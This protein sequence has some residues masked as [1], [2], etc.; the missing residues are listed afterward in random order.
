MGTPWLVG[1]DR[2]TTA[3]CSEQGTNPLHGRC[4][5]PNRNPQL[6]QSQIEQYLKDYLGVSNV[7]WLGEGIVGDDT[8]GHID[9]ITRFVNPTTV[10]TV[11][12]EDPADAN[13][14]LLQ[15]NLKR[16]RGLSDQDGSKLRIVE[17]PM[18]GVVEYDGQRLPSSYA[19]FYIANGLVLVPTYRHAN[20]KKAVAI[21]QK[22][23]PDRRVVG[24]D[25]TELIWGLGSFHCITQQE[26]RG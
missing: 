10:V 12:E 20:D 11:V 26:P 1:D 4:V 14:H 22:E 7:L 23:F 25:S 19:N 13:Y 21:L 2:H 8:D 15:E 9:D 3:D 18:P 24:V 6:N 17:L 5:A 16:L